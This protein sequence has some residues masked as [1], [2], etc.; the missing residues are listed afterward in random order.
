MTPI[1]SLSVLIWKPTSLLLE[2]PQTAGDRQDLTVVQVLREGV[3]DPVDRTAGT[4][5]DDP[6]RPPVAVDREPAAVDGAP[7]VGVVEDRRGPSRPGPGAPG[8]TR[9]ATRGGPPGP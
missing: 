7:L 1:G 2:P 3:G 6:D 9:R 4:P 8:T 5:G